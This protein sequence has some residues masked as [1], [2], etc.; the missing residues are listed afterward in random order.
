MAIVSKSQL[1]D[2]FRNG[3]K[4]VQEQFWNWMDSVWHKEEKIP[5]SSID[6]L[7]NYFNDIASDLNSRAMRDASNISEDDAQ[8]WRDLLGNIDRSEERRVGKECGCRW[9]WYGCG[10]CVGHS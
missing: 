5:G 7:E 2:W 3:L 1:N 8:K 4:P 6:G 9:C 10:D